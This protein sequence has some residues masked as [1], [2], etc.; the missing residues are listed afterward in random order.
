MERK[1]VSIV[2]LSILYLLT[3]VPLSLC[4][5]FLDVVTPCG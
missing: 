4:S 1:T 2:N 5:G 3:S